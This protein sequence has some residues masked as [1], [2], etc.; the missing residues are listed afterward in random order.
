[1]MAGG[2]PT[3]YC[4]EIADKICELVAT[5]ECG[6]DELCEK[7]DWM[8]DQSTVRL[9]R[10]K[11]SL[12]SAKYLQAKQSQAELFAEETFK[13]A[14]HKPIYRDAEG[15]ERIDPGYVAWQKMNVN[16]RQW[17]AAKLAP[18]VYGDKQH[19][20]TVITHEEKIQDLS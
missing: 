18:R 7:F 1:M 14:A 10:F 6:L 3:L 2:R 17:H 11:H 19:I 13:I 12:F 9:W 8:P 5:H 20:E 15:N 16:L 4:D